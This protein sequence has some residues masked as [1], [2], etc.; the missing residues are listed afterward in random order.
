MKAD[1]VVVDL[2][3]RTGEYDRDVRRSADNFEQGAKRTVNAARDV[4]RAAGRVGNA[5][6]NLSFQLSD[7]GVQ[8]SGGTSPFIVIS[9]QGPQVVQALQDISASGARFGQV[10]RGIALPGAL[11]LISVL[12]PLA[13]ALLDSGDAADGATGGIDRYSTS[14]ENLKKKAEEALDEVAKLQTPGSN[15]LSGISDKVVAAAAADAKA[16]AARLE[17]ARVQNTAVISGGD[18]AADAVAELQRQKEIARLKEEIASAEARASD[19]R[20]SNRVLLAND[21][22]TR[23]EEQASRD[24]VSAKRA[25]IEARKQN[26]AATKDERE[27]L[28]D[29]AKLQAEV[30]RLQD[31]FDPAAASARKFY[32][33][34]DLIADLERK[35]LLKPTEA[36]AYRIAAALDQANF[37]LVD[38]KSIY[39]SDPLADQR[40]ALEREGELKEQVRA[41]DF[42]KRA[43]DIHRLADLYETA[44]TD[45]A[46]GIWNHFERDGL[47]VMALI[48]AKFTLLRLSG[49]GGGGFFGDLLSVGKT[50]VGSYLGGRASGGQVTAGHLYRVNEG[51]SPGRVEAFR[52]AGS[53]EVIPLGRTQAAQPRG[54]VTIA[55]SIAID[56][57][58]ATN[59]AETYRVAKQAAYDALSETAPMLISGAR[60]ATVRQLTRPRL[61]GSLG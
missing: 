14:M 51:S 28:R 13:T 3:A 29:A 32:D 36:A 25:E 34:L 55:P 6:R 57:R 2:V 47:R 16:R 39:G 11:A 7:I 52:P 60:S 59:P 46:S 8:L 4:E 41:E 18:P 17:L 42:A 43:D 5:T 30:E 53:G 54:G 12:A 37:K 22:R 49:G 10:M 48:L 15:R 56:A 40:K 38:V 24:A 21:A 26:A 9:Q 45:G 19:L 61:P 50:V 58:G 35:G 44:F 27:A 33:T 23:A 31:R 20:A 1:E